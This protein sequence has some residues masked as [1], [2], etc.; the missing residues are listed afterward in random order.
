MRRFRLLTL[1]TIAL[2]VICLVPAAAMAQPSKTGEFI[3][4]FS[5]RSPL[6]EKKELLNRLGKKDPG[7]DYDLA[8][9]SF[10]VY[11]PHDYDASVPHGLIVWMNY[12]DVDTTPKSLQ[13]LLDKSHT[14]F[15]VS[16]SAGQ[17]D[18]IRAGLALDAVQNIK[19][20]YTI[21]EKR[22]YLFALLQPDQVIGQKMGLS[23]ADAFTGFV[24][25]WNQRY[26]RPIPIPGEP[27][28][29]YAVSFSKPNLPV[30]NIAKTRK[31]VLIGDARAG[32]TDK[33]ILKAYEQ[34]GFHSMFYTE[35]AFDDLHYPS[36]QTGWFEKTMQFLD[37]PDQAV[38]STHPTETTRPA[39]SE[40]Q[41]M[42]NLAKTY[43]GMK[44]YPVARTKLQD[45]IRKFPD[46]PAAAEAKQL[47][48]QI[49]G[50]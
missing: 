5:K 31:H 8:S 23:Y 14:I 28:T 44:N 2:S 29:S 21:D 13:P 6:S 33:L 17:E 25:I 24:Y 12:K 11:V 47:L 20:L 3:T 36:I 18:W 15:V 35:A 26:F 16:K 32:G 41:R 49:S 43:L 45:V 7:K 50:K 1:A 9:E 22:V 10:M 30:Y 40:P 4:T 37:A 46:D 19:Q 42:L 34:D 48:E 38:A 39:I 27:G